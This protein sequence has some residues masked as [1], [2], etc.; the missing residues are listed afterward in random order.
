MGSNSPRLAFGG[1][2]CAIPF[3]S[4]PMNGGRG[5][6]SS[7]LLS[8]GTS[9]SEAGRDCWASSGFGSWSSSRQKGVRKGLGQLVRDWQRTSRVA[10]RCCGRWSGRSGRLAIG[11]IVCRSSGDCAHCWRAPL[12]LH[13][14]E[15]I[16]RFGL[17]PR[18][19]RGS[20]AGGN[21]GGGSSLAFDM[22]K[23][24]GGHHRPG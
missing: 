12:S 13:T 15:P 7:S 14:F 16:P 11:R 4:L 22:R 19:A 10:T 21:L 18:Q 23:W 17:R 3:G 20:R 5:V 8:S 24:D 9:A 1:F 2:N 6:L